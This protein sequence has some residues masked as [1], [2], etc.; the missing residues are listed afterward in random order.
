[1]R[2][3]LD[4]DPKLLEE[5]TKLTQE[6]NRSKAVKKAL[7]EYIRAKRIADLRSMLG[8]LDLVDNWYE[9]RHAEPR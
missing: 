5:I 2:T 4:I 9:L 1:M 6:D 3:T 8:K 7:E